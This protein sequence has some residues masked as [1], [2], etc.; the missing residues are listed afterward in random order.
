MAQLSRP[1]GA[2]YVGD[3]G[4][5][6]P[7]RLPTFNDRR[8]V[9]CQVVPCPVCKA[10]IGSACVSTE[11]GDKVRTHTPRTRMANRKRNESLALNLAMYPD[12]LTPRE[13]KTR[14]KAV[15]LSATQLDRILGAAEG[16]IQRA[17]T[18]ISLPRD[19]A[20]IEAYG[21]LLRLWG[22]R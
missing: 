2:H 21:A 13:R 11:T 8:R 3:P 22:Q 14:R 9:D 1:S 19:L 18:G 15:G 5:H 12:T 10:P 6:T 7:T 20:T 16:T 4:D 17:E